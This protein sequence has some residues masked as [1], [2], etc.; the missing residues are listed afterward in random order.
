MLT[1]SMFNAKIE[2]VM[3]RDRDIAGHLDYGIYSTIFQFRLK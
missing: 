3:T 1:H 2:A